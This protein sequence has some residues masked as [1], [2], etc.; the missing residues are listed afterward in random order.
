VVTCP[1]H[2]WRFDVKTGACLNVPGKVQ[3]SLPVRE[4]GGSILVEV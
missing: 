4:E 3:P 1:W 2:G